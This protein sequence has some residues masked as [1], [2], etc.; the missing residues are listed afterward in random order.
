[1]R[2]ANPI[3]NEVDHYDV[4]EPG[5]GWDLPH[6][7][8]GA[9]ACFFFPSIEPTQ[10]TQPSLATSPNGK[11]ILWLGRFSNAPVGAKLSLLCSNVRVT[12]Y[13]NAILFLSGFSANTSLPPTER[14]GP[15]PHLVNPINPTP[16]TSRG[17]AAPSSWGRGLP[18]HD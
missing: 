11:M 10:V 16:N 2:I 9:E 12:L 4:G 14:L 6:H 5:V 8:V 17:I 13:T 18:S 1:M 3:S 7:Q 15:L